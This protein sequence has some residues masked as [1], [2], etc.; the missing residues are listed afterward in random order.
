METAFTR[1]KNLTNVVVLVAVLFVQVLGLAVQVKK[2]TDAGS[3]RLIRYWAVSIVT[4]FEKVVVHTEDWGRRVWNNYVDLRQVRNENRDLRD[5]LARMRLEQVRLIEDANQARRLQLLLGFKEQYMSQTV[6]A[7]VISTTGS[8]FSRGIYIDKGSKA[9]IRQD[10]PVITPEGVIGKVLRVYPG[11]SLVLEINDPTSG[12]GVILEKSR[13]Q[14]ILR[15]DSSGELRIHYIM[16][17]ESVQP[18]ERVFTSGGD[19]V[20]PKGLP[21]GAI[22]QVTPG[23]ET[24]LNITVKPAAHLSRAEEVLVI[25]KIDEKAANVDMAATPVRAIDVLAG[26]LPTVPPPA[27]PKPANTGTA[28]PKPGVKPQASVAGTAAA[29]LPKREAE[30]PATTGAPKPTGS[31]GIES[32]GDTNPTREP[33]STAPELK[34]PVAPKNAGPINA[35]PA[36]PAPSAIGG[37]TSEKPAATT[38]KEPPR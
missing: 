2:K 16:N 35:R 29:T 12:I 5:E 17:D 24:F 37:N 9:G 22:K 7:Q 13:V 10:M 6:P 36:A 21:V 28:T 20:F 26:R 32:A 30:K 34:P 19:R 27:P 38:P 8:D 3:V 23:S 4:P 15:G 25:T 31:T 33:V 11:T 14:G 1:H 18:G